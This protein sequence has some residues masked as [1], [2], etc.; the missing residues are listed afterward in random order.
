LYTYN[1]SI[2]GPVNTNRIDNV[3]AGKYYLETKDILGCPKI[4][5]VIVTEPNGMILAASKLSSSPDDAYNISCN[6]GNDG[7]IDI[8]VAG[9]SGNYL[10][11]WT[12]PNGFSATTED[13]TGLKAGVYSCTVRDL[14]G[15][16]LTPA[17]AFTLTEPAVLSIS[18]IPSVSADGSFEINC[19]GGTGAIDIRF[20]EEVQGEHLHMEHCRRIWNYAGTA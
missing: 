16:I 14:N 4:D 10:Y 17:P 5:S 18:G 7:S 13:I 6:G 3:T 9:G 20:R 12:G 19:N 11:N 2:P 1:G 8:T 15:C